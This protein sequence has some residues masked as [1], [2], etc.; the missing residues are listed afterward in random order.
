MGQRMIER[1]LRETS[2]RLRR[3]REELRIV[4][5]Q[6]AHLS[7]EADDLGLRAL[8]SETPGAS[9]EYRE[10]R[11]HADAMRTHREEVAAGI[12]ELEARQ[13]QLLEKLSHG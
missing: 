7:D 2:D 8:V 10:A 9:A 6:L 3:L 11:L 4:D 5:E 1:R 12:H 13:D